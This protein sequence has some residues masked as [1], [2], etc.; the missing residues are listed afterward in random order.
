MNGYLLL[1]R[2]LVICL[3]YLHC[4]CMLWI[5][6][7]EVLLRYLRLFKDFVHDMSQDKADKENQ[8]SDLF[9]MNLAILS[10]YFFSF[11]LVIHKNFLTPAVYLT[12]KT[13]YTQTNYLWK[14]QQKKEKGRN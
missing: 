5:L 3:I 13:C 2:V 11:S 1:L 10:S 7:I 4:L 12:E 9:I 6:N 8:S 14:R